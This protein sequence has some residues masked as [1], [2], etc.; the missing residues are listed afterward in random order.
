MK[1]LYATKT[2]GGDIDKVFSYHPKPDLVIGN[3]LGFDF[4]DMGQAEQPYYQPELRAVYEAFKRE[5]TH[6][7]WYASDVKPPEGDW[8]TPAL[9]LLGDYPMVSPFWTEPYDSYV[10]LA[11]RQGHGGFNEKEWGFE[12]EIF[13]DHVYLAKVDTM[14]RIDYN[15]QHDVGKF[16]PQHGGDSFEKRVGQWLASTGQKRAVLRDFSYRHTTGDEK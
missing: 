9:K 10:D 6:I 7:L 11:K 12:T 2:W 3:N 15:T 8:V 1:I 13:S 16:Y 14:L 5:A 4:V